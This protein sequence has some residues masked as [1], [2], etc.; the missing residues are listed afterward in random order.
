M[1]AATC[2]DPR[3]CVA[4]RASPLMLPPSPPPLAP[5]GWGGLPSRAQQPGLRWG[6]ERTCPEH[7]GEPGARASPTVAISRLQSPPLP[8][9][10]LQRRGPPAMAWGSAE[11]SCT[12]TTQQSRAALSFFS[13]EADGA[14]RKRPCRQ[15]R[16]HQRACTLGAPQQDRRQAVSPAFSSTISQGPPSHHHMST[17]GQQN[18]GLIPGYGLGTSYRV[19]QRSASVCT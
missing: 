17:L 9:E 3:L 8:L 18:Q 11:H 13:L 10:L 7:G 5:W 2:L 6:P 15:D 14:T 12:S 16:G 1:V 4:V 19:T